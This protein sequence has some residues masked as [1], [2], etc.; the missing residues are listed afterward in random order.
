[1]RN[2]IE[3][4]KSNKHIANLLREAISQ[5]GNVKCLSLAL[6]MNRCTIIS[7]ING[8]KYPCK[9]SIAKLEVY[10]SH[11]MNKQPLKEPTK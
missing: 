9:A 2:K 7:W 5:A 8:D 11:S 10:L 3:I 1:M 6:K 4:C